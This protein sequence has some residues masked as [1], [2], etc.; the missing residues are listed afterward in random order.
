[1]TLTAT[2]GTMADWNAMAS[3]K[4]AQVKLEF[5]DAEEVG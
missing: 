3:V 4:G 5:K 2:T 1:M